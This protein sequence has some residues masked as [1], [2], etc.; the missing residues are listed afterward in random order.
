LW[1]GAAREGLYAEASE[2]CG[3]WDGMY[4]CADGGVQYEEPVVG[5]AGRMY[6]LGTGVDISGGET[7]VGD[8]VCAGDCGEDGW[9]G[10]EEDVK[11]EEDVNGEGEEE[12]GVNGEG[13]DEEGGE[14]GGEGVDGGVYDN[15]CDGE[16]L[17]G[18]GERERRGD[19]VLDRTYE[20]GYLDI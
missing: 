20:E 9:G 12:E 2:W 5:F 16:C 13:E 8:G 4:E 10:G 1:G 19:G 15:A 6:D 11:G 7:G 17:S 18:G 14:N 3:V